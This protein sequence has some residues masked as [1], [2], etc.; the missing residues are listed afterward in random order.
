MY[1]S[2]QGK[3]VARLSHYKTI[4]TPPLPKGQCTVPISTRVRSKIGLAIA[5]ER[6]YMLDCQWH[7]LSR[8]KAASPSKVLLYTAVGIHEKAWNIIRKHATGQKWR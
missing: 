5:G 1:S 2:G 3:Y 7:E 4:D 6:L 8:P